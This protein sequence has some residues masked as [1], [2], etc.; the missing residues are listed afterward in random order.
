MGNSVASFVVGFLYFFAI[1]LSGGAGFNQASIYTVVVAGVIF[2][3][4]H[5][6]ARTNVI[7]R[8]ISERDFE[9]VLKLIIYGVVWN[10]ILMSIFFGIGAGIRFLVG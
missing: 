10:S 8:A 2:T 6:V 7:G 4:G 9:V 3:V 1:T 5:Q